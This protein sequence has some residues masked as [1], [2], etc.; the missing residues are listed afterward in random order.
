MPSIQRW[1]L[2]TRSVLLRAATLAPQGCV[3]AAQPDKVATELQVILHRLVSVQPV[4][5]DQR[6]VNKWTRDGRPP[7]ISTALS[8]QV[9]I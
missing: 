9:S 5:P 1:M 8:I 7:G 2:M 3:V 6:P 4:P